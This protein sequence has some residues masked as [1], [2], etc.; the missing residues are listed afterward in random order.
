MDVCTFLI[1]DAQTTKLIEPGEGSLH[2]P[3]PPSQPT[4]VFCV[5]HR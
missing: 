4:S 3:S 1:A 5:A 2:D